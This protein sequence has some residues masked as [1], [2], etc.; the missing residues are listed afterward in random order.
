MSKLGKHILE[1]AYDND[2]NIDY[3]YAVFPDSFTFNGVP[4]S[5]AFGGSASPTIDQLYY[6]YTS[7][8]NWSDVRDSLTVSCIFVIDE[9]DALYQATGGSAA[10]PG[11]TL[12]VQQALSKNFLIPKA[13][14]DLIHTQ[15]EQEQFALE[16]YLCTTDSYEKEKLAD[17]VDY[18]SIS[19]DGDVQDF[20][21]NEANFVGGGGSGSVSSVNGQSGVVILNLDDLSD[22]N[23]SGASE[24]NILIHN[25]SNWTTQLRPQLSI[26]P[27]SQNYMNYNTT[28]GE[29]FLEQLAIT[30]VTVIDSVTQSSDYF[31][32]PI[33]CDSHEEGDTVVFPNATDGVEVWMHNGGSSLTIAD[34]VQIE[35]PSVSESFVKA[36]LSAE[37]PIYYD[38]ATGVISITQSGTA[39]D[40]YLSAADYNYFNDKVDTV[41]GKVGTVILT[42]SDIVEGTNKYYCAECAYADFNAGTGLGFNDVNGTYYALI[43][44]TATAS[45]TVLWSAGKIYNEIDAIVSG[46][47]GAVSSVNGQSGVVSLGLNSI[48]TVDND[49][50]GIDLNIHTGDSITFDNTID[51]IYKDASGTLVLQ[52]ATKGIKLIGNPN[53][54]Q[55]NYNSSGLTVGASSS[56]TSLKFI[57]NSVNPTIQATDSSSNIGILDFTSIGLTSTRTWQMPDKSG[58]VALLSDIATGSNGAVDS[59][60]GATGTVILNLNDI[61]DVNTSGVND[62][63]VL[64]YNGATAEWVGTT[65]S[66]SGDITGTG[67]SGY[68]AVWNDTKDLT[69]GLIQDDGTGV[70]INTAPS[71]SIQLN[72][73]AEDKR[74]AM[75]IA[76]SYSGTF[77]SYGFLYQAISTSSR[78]KYGI[79]SLVN[80]GTQ[81]VGM[82]GAAVTTSTTYPG[83][84]DIGVVGQSRNSTRGNIGVVGITTVNSTQDNIGG[85]F[86]ASNAGA[87]NAYV[88][89]LIDGN[90]ANG[91]VLTSD[92]NGNASWQDPIMGTGASSSVVSVNGYTG[93]VNLAM[94]DITDVDTVTSTASVGD[95]LSWDGS[96]WTPTTPEAVTKKAWTWGAASARSN[97][98]D[99]YIYKYNGTPTNISPY[100]AFKDCKILNMSVATSVAETW[101]AETR[102]NGVVA[103]SMSISGTSSAWTTLDVSVNAGDK[104]AFYCNGS[105]IDSPSIEILLQEI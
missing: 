105:A 81:N 20:I 38:T 2:L 104:I 28:T 42:T 72:V 47:T 68:L 5:T 18:I 15:E 10:Y 56:S 45:N 39:S 89:Q 6:D 78:K 70:G 51:T 16:L 67:S 93:I 21:R 79:V 50:N 102:I 103:A 98:T 61:N 97:T 85:Y 65:N 96:H 9:I 88:L 24:D 90:Q 26:H 76:S 34:Y 35:N 49:T 86:Q 64:T 55:G 99:S 57:V 59:V 31:N 25:G 19:D 3:N 63:Y 53:G 87:G 84:Y 82:I 71:S 60:N 17:A 1:Q 46:A 22:V 37:A 75:Q 30:D 73:E 52:G 74:I 66:A 91:R 27:D 7:I 33:N 13:D 77:D 69:F 58:V 8:E 48:L 23:V 14:R 80:G 36:Q 11:L 43:D 29:L 12:S 95:L 100:I 32:N 40:G 44:D 54:V 83:N 62:G 4:G 94:N 101:I 41:N 92:A